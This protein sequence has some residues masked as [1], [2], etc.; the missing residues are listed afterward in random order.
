MVVRSTIG[1]VVFRMPYSDK[2]PAIVKTALGDGVK[3][4]ANDVP[5]PIEPTLTPKEKIHNRLIDRRL[6]SPSTLYSG[7]GSSGSAMGPIFEED[8]TV[9]ESD[10][11]TSKPTVMQKYLEEQNAKFD[12]LINKNLGEVL[13]QQNQ[14]Q[15]EAGWRELVF[16]LAMARNSSDVSSNLGLLVL[17]VTR[18]AYQWIP[19]VESATVSPE[20]EVGGESI[21]HD[22]NNNLI[23]T[24][25][26]T[27]ESMAIE[28]MDY[29]GKVRLL[30]QLQRDLGMESEAD[31]T[32]FMQ[33]VSLESDPPLVDKIQMLMILLI[34]MAFMG[35]KLFIPIC[36]AIY[37]K[38]QND[39]LMVFNNRNFNRLLNSVIHTM[40]SM[41]DWFDYESHR[42]SDIGVPTIEILDDVDLPMT[43]G[44]SWAAAVARYTMSAWTSNDIDN[45]DFAND[46]RYAQYF[47]DRRKAFEEEESYLRG[48][49][50]TVF[51]VAQQFAHEMG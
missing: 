38:F 1:A 2:L 21:V 10:S 9:R 19:F 14:F 46:P 34:R 33:R 5:D 28:S 32:N 12:D 8:E 20:G 7:V 24:E 43:G 25:P 35:I 42:N 17:R 27:F 13:K 31:I 4:V 45:T 18:S 51:Q 50:P 44:D 49:H 15:D 23:R 40:A 36:T 29:Q 37:T 39:D 30:R 16:S 22:L 3:P 41:E 11:E 6:E 26:S 48:D 47:T